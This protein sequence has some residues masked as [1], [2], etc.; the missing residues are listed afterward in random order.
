MAKGRVDE[1]YA[2][3]S[4][5]RKADLVEAEMLE[6]ANAA[7]SLKLQRGARAL[8]APEVRLE[9]FVGAAPFLLATPIAP[10]RI[11]TRHV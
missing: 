5:L 2:A 7:A 11:M 1:A 6:A 4:K 8:Q 3:L 9:L 10:L